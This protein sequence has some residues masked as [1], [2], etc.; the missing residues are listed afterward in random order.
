[1]LEVTLLFDITKRIFL[2]WKFICVFSDI[3]D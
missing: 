2:I 1:V 3:S